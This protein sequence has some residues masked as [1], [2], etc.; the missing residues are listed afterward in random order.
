GGVYD[1]LGGGFFRYSVDEKWRIPHFEKMLYD[2]GP[3]LA[4]CA[5]AS[6]ATGLAVFRR[7]TTETADW[8][9]R[10]M[11]AEQGGF[12]STLDADSEGEEGLFYAWDAAD[13]RTVA[14]NEQ[15]LIADHFG[16]DEPANFEGRHHL[17]QARPV[18]ELAKDNAQTETELQDRIDKVRSRLFQQR[19]GRIHPDRDEKILTGWNAMMIRGLAIAARSTDSEK[20]EQAASRCL[21]FIQEALWQDSR[22]MATWKD[23]QPRFSAYLDDHAFLIDAIL[24]LLQCRWSGHDLNF[25]IKLADVLLLHFAD[26]ENGGFYFTA[27]DHEKLFHRSRPLSDDSTPSGNAIAAR[28]LLRLGYLLGETRYLD[29]AENTLRSAWDPM[30][31][32]PHA[33]TSMINTLA[34]YL[35]PPEI[36]VLRGTESKLRQW[37]KR[38]TKGY[39]PD[40]LVF[41]IPADASGL[42]EGLA[43]RAARGEIFAYQCRGHQCTAGKSLDELTGKDI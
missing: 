27:D 15:A 32:N 34:E 4:L 28:A 18:G 38:L 43:I 14:A 30:S 19:A 25:A 24:E 17:W 35:Q 6:D 11:A 22:L 16:L 23:G 12:Y 13:V 21:A 8:A 2:N 26:R 40:R 7:A 5:Q 37:Q 41:A 33:H 20:Y 9:L 3:L 1:Q 31:Q 39:Q 29:A 36:L 42:P 10:E